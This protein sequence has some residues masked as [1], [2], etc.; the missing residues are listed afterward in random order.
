LARR[1]NPERLGAPQPDAPP[2]D[3][4][5]PPE[6]QVD[7]L[8][9]VVPTEFVALPTEGAYY[10]DGHPLQKA[11][12]VEIKYMTAKEED[13]LSSRSLLEKGLVLDRLLENLLV[14]KHIRSRDLLMADRNAIL[15]AARSSGY[16]EEYKTKIMCRSCT[17]SDSY[18]YD[19][20]NA[21]STGPLSP[22][23]LESIN[24]KHKG[25]GVFAV[26]VPNA[27]VEVEFRLLSGHDERAMMDLATKRKKKKMNDQLITDQL[28]FM[29]VSVMGHED[30]EIIGQYVD[31]LPLRDSRFLRDTYEKVTPS[32]DLR[33]EFVCNH[34]GYEDDII[35]PFTVDF[36]WPDAGV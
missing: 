24:V 13:L 8:S 10:P 5:L 29:I 25:D 20:N 23:E 27:P 33:K 6:Q 14:D 1:N 34:C 3:A 30:P 26:R 28:N 2:P 32:L 19:L 21:V 12:S 15:V 36:F 35:F 22:E 4:A 31:S 17:E 18:S 16:G 9:F 7:P 11:D